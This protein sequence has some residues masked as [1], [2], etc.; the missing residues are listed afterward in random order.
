[1]QLTQLEIEQF[2]SYLF[3]KMPEEEKLALENKLKSDSEFKDKFEQYTALVSAIKTSAREA[4]KKKIAKEGAVHYLKNSWGKQW[5]LIYAA[6]FILFIAMFFVFEYNLQ[7]KLLPNKKTNES[8]VMEES[9][10]SDENDRSEKS[11]RA[12]KRKDISNELQEDTSQNVESEILEDEIEI[13]EEISFV[14]EDLEEDMLDTI[15]TTPSYA[16]GNSSEK[17]SSGSVPQAPALAESNNKKDADTEVISGQLLKDSL[18]NAQVISQEILDGESD[19]T[20]MSLDSKSVQLQFW[21][22]PLNSKVYR[23]TQ[24]SNKPFI[25]IYGIDPKTIQGIFY[26]KGEFLLLGN[27]VVYRFIPNQSYLPLKI[28]RNKELVNT[29]ERIK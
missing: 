20:L 29:L 16:F 23:F 4:F 24:K 22:S 13:E 2:D 10:T 28:D 25:E 8:I 19:S 26:L 27:G 3:G 7:D 12:K 6:I 14:T 9:A 18:Y 21:K 1:M 11:T 17:E 5:T 15:V